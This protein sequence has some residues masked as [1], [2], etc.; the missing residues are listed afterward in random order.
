[1]CI[2]KYVSMWVLFGKC[3]IYVLLG[4][5]ILYSGVV[6]QPINQY[7][8]IW[9]EFNL[10]RKRVVPRHWKMVQKSGSLLIICICSSILKKK[11]W[12][13]F[14]FFVLTNELLESYSKKNGE[15]IFI[16]PNSNKGRSKSICLIFNIFLKICNPLCNN[17]LPI[18]KVCLE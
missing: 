4:I 12:V 7:A 10:L 6:R 14:Y 1:M 18:H 2:Q 15:S 5:N 11:S 17:N 16:Q 8:S 13:V 9:K 3:T